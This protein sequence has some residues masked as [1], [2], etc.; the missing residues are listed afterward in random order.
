MEARGYPPGKR[1]S[2]A[3]LS[4]AAVV[5][6]AIVSNIFNRPHYVPEPHVMVD[7]AKAL[8]ISHREILDAAAAVSRAKSNHRQTNGTA[9]RRKPK[10]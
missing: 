8:R 4:R 10:G 3:D 7:L 9:G 2:K 5:E 6:D 1:G